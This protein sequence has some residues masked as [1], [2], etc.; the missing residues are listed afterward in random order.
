MTVFCK[1]GSGR[2]QNKSITSNSAKK[3]SVRLNFNFHSTLNL[4]LFA[5][6]GIIL[7]LNVII[8]YKTT[9]VEY[10]LNQKRL[11]LNTV[12]QSTLQGASIEEL[13]SYIEKVGMV[14]NKVK[15]TLQ[16]DFGVALS[17]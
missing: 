11:D 10:T 1:V 16:G 9:V 15:V 7:F 12:S 5:V 8:P 6:V 2:T 4:L 17:N 14:E 13:L 3:S